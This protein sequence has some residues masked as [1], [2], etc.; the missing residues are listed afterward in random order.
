MLWPAAVFE[1]GRALLLH[2]E[3][4]ATAFFVSTQQLQQCIRCCTLIITAQLS[5]LFNWRAAAAACSILLWRRQA[6]DRQPDPEGLRAGA[7]I[8]VRNTC[9]QGLETYA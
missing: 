6:D 9:Q 2:G 1:R 7:A 5:S 3:E 8:A 4:P